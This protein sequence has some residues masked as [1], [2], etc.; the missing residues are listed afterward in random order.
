MNWIQ[1]NWR[2]VG[3][4]IVAVLWAGKAFGPSVIEAGKKAIAAIRPKVEQK[5]TVFSG[6]PLIL[7]AILL[8]PSLM[9]TPA[10]APVPPVTPERVPDL[11]DQCAA[12]G[13]ILL[14]DEL[15]KI[16]GQQFANVQDKE[17]AINTKILDVLDASL[18]PFNKR[19]AEAAKD[20]RLTEFTSKVR[21]GDIRE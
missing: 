3:A 15:D 13:R 21:K 2:I 9:P 5:T 18:E 12:A 4:V 11:F 7:I 6:L 14:C 8:G 19:L 17:D 1:S 16:A 10:P 20:N